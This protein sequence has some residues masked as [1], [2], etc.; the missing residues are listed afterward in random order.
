M[1]LVSRNSEIF[2]PQSHCRGGSEESKEGSEEGNHSKAN[3][4]CPSFP[5]IGVRILLT[6]NFRSTLGVI[7]NTKSYSGSDCR[8][9]SSV[10]LPESLQKLQD[11]NVYEVGILCWFRASKHHDLI[12]LWSI[13]TVSQREKH[14]RKLKPELTWMFGRF[15]VF[16]A[17]RNWNIAPAVRTEWVTINSAR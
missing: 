17:I 4:F 6:L 9:T 2:H 15:G 10:E 11:C 8:E 7:R 3:G 1:R 12:P 13:T 5:N 14:L 16:S